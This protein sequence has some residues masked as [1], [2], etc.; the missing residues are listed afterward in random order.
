MR[1]MHPTVY[2]FRHVRNGEVIWSSD[3]TENALTNEGEQDILAVYF[4]KSKSAPTNFYIGLINDAGIAETDTL[5][6][7]AGEP[8]G[9]GYARSECTFGT[10]A[11]DA[12]D[13]ESVSTTETFTASG[14][15]IGPVTHAFLTNAASGTSGLFLVYVAL[16]ATRTL[17]DGDSL[18][19]DIAVKVS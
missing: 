5:A 16:S 10:P 2:R 12:G 6:T 13:Y 9:N 8:S 11:L 19:V 3:W 17:L 1:E 15:S 4:A 7:M 14:G 18:Q